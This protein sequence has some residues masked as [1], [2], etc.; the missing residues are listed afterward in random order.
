MVD[1]KP[2][3]GFVARVEQQND[4]SYLICLNR[5]HLCD[6]KLGHF[7]CGRSCEEREIVGKV[8][9]TVRKLNNPTGIDF[10]CISVT[11]P[12]VSDS[13]MRKIWCPRSFKISFP[14]E[15][16]NYIDINEAISKYPSMGVKYVNKLPEWNDELKSLVLKFQGNRVLTA[17]AKNFLLYEEKYSKMGSTRSL[18]SSKLARS[19]SEESCSM[20]NRFRSNTNSSLSDSN[21]NYSN[22]INDSEESRQYINVTQS[23]S[24]N[25]TL[26][27]SAT[28]T[29]EDISI[30]NTTTTNM[31]NTTTTTTNSSNSKPLP[32]R[33]RT[34][35]AEEDLI[36]RNQRPRARTRSNRSDDTDETTSLST[37]VARAH[38]SKKKPIATRDASKRNSY[39]R[40]F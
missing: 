35:T 1:M 28:N 32:S 31:N 38:K 15:V 9:H 25:V 27:T 39:Y 40:D 10:R 4:S 17:S 11:L 2:K 26:T 6:G 30:D 37:P 12:I 24:T 16:G 21:H 20:G 13:G 3:K 7:T 34:T 23:L 14:I 19:N 5:C 36:F 33:S 18:N 29:A 8:S 22:H